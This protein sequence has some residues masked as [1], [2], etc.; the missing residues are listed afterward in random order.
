MRVWLAEFT[1]M[2]S[3]CK[4]GKLWNGPIWKQWTTGLDMRMWTELKSFVAP[5]LSVSDFIKVIHNEEIII[6]HSFR[7]KIY[8]INPIWFGFRFPS[9]ILMSQT[10]TKTQ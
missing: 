10:R 8:D 2:E 5:P 3:W 6:L 7:A 4:R 1:N 9:Q